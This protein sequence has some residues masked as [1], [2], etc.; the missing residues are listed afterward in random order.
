MDSVDPNPITTG[1]FLDPNGAIE[2][3]DFDIYGRLFGGDSLGIQITGSDLYDPV[4][5]PTSLVLLGA[6]LAG[7]GAIRRRRR[8]PFLRS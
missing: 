5:E 7:L 6:G 2:I 4:P 1:T 3:T 8:R